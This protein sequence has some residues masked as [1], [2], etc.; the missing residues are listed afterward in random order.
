MPISLLASLSC[1]I[2][3]DV[4]KHP[5]N[6]KSIPQIDPTNYLALF[7]RSCSL[8]IRFQTFSVVMG[9][10]NPY[11]PVSAPGLF[12]GNRHAVTVNLGSKSKPGISL[13][14]GRFDLMCGLYALLRANSKQFKKASLIFTHQ[15]LQKKSQ[16][17]QWL[18]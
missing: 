16:N 9:E 6:S 17:P 5:L 1:E 11:F 8:K 13:V 10:R 14:L 3:S 7:R 15:N 2:Y 4:R 12:Y 18:P